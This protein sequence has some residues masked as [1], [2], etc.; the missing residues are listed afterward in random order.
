[1][2]RI[3][4]EIFVYWLNLL[5]KFEEENYS[6]LYQLSLNDTKKQRKLY[7]WDQRKLFVISHILLYQTS[8]YRVSTVYVY[9]FINFLFFNFLFQSSSAAAA[10]AALQQNMI[11]LQSHQIPNVPYA[12]QQQGNG[13][14]Q[15]NKCL[16]MFYRVPKCDVINFSCFL[17]FIIFMTIFR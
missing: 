1:M 2:Y 4:F 13:M 11:Q 15:G 3:L 7:H 10:S 9:I 14:I 17:H 5:I 16:Y 6:L 12:I 8:L